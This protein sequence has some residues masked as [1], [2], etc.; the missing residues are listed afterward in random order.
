MNKALALAAIV[1]AGLSV[2]AVAFAGTGDSA[3]G[4]GQRSG[5]TNF[6][7]LGINLPQSNFGFSGRETPQGIQG[8]VSFS[9]PDSNG[10]AAQFT[11]EVTCLSVAGNR[12]TVAG[13]IRESHGAFGDQTAFIFAVEDNGDPVKG[14]SRNRMT[15]IL[16]LPQ[17]AAFAGLVFG[18]GIPTACPVPATALFLAVLSIPIVHG[19]VRVQDH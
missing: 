8:E 12:V 4:G 6:L 15:P 5:V 17:R 11:G 1:L 3:V 10:T 7:G 14:T 19:N 18:P 2:T 13:I 16:T 9:I